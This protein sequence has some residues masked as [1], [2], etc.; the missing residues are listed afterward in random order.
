MLSFTITI[1]VYMWEMWHNESVKEP[2]C[3]SQAL[4]NVSIG[5]IETMKFYN[6]SL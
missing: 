5:N 6:F 3:C 4:E 2:G 1:E